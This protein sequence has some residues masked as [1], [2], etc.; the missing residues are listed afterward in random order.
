[1]PGFL[2]FTFDEQFNEMTTQEDEFEI[3]KTFSSADEA[4][5]LG[6]ALSH[7]GIPVRVKA[8]KEPFDPTFAFNPLNQKVVVMIRRKDF[9]EV[10][11]ALKVFAEENLDQIDRPDH[12]LREFSDAELM[13]ILKKQDEWI[14]EDV[15]LA[16]KLL[17]DRGITISEEKADSMRSERIEEIRKEEAGNTLIIVV[18]YIFAFVGG[19][20]AIFIGFRYYFSKITDPDGRQHHTYDKK[21]RTHGLV[22]MILASAWI[23]ALAMV[24]LLA[25]SMVY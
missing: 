20:P 23:F 6:D 13:D 22:M 19:L 11:K 21:T 18:G 3:Y 8:K 25:F 15:V 24:Q 14:I 10:Q 2:Y 5:Y 12:Y 4:R 9:G 1:M 7:V 17:A 16:R